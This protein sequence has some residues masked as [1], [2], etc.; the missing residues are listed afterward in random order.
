MSGIEVGTAFV[1]IMPLLDP[2]FNAILAGQV[3]AATGVGGANTK[4]AASANAATAS[5]KTLAGTQTVSAAAAARIAGAELAVARANLA[6][7]T[8]TETLNAAIAKNVGAMEIQ[9]LT[10]KAAIASQ[11]ANVAQ[12]RLNSALAGT[13]ARAAK[14][15]VDVW[16]AGNAARGALIGLSRITPVAVFGL[17]VMGTA[18]IAAGLALKAAVSSASDFQSQMNTLQAVTKATDAEMQKLNLV[19][20]NDKK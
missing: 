5:T 11:A 12:L 13:P 7:A 8:A 17:G 16:T 20:L 10:Q 3:S 19:I 4:L 15:L 2:S 18:A 6:A 9:A 1:R 14:G